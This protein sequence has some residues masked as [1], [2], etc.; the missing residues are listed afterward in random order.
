MG[1]DE[2]DPSI[3]L[4]RPFL[5]T[6]KAIIYI[7]TR[8]I[9]FKFPSEKVQYHFNNN[10]II[11]EESTKNR[12]RRRQRTHHQKKKNVIDRWAD[13]EREVSRFKDQYLDKENIVKEEVPTEEE[14]VIPDT[15]SSKSPSPTGWVWKPK[16]NLESNPTQHIA[17]LAPFDVPFNH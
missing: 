4:G 13:F 10:Y 3:I 8:E 14:I 15:L 16:I 5:N 9:H 2:C 17:P 6:T 11:D 7:G 1:E 12:S